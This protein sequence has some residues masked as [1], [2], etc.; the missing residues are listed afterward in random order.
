MNSSVS[1]PMQI[2]TNGSPAAMLESKSERRF[3]LECF[4]KN[5]APAL[6][7]L[8]GTLK[9][10]T[11]SEKRSFNPPAASAPRPTVPPPMPK[12]VTTGPKPVG[13]VAKGDRRLHPR[14]ESACVVS[15][16]V[17]ATQ[18]EL[19][20]QRIA[21][22]LHSSRIKGKLLDV[23]MSGMSLELYEPVEAGSEVLLRVNSRN[24]KSVVDV[25]AKVLRCTAHDGYFNIICRLSKNL[26]F[27]QIHQ[28]GNHLF[29]S[30]IV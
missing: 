25:T 12:P 6:Q 21:W 29:S 4:S 14:R 1:S 17:K 2:Q 26:T 23:S 19:S 30:T 13:K 20:Q 3:A 5:R 18:G 24:I 28:V 27:E 16:C 7:L 22:L 9:R 11:H 10:I 15:V 8:A